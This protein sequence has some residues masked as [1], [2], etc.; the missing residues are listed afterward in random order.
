MILLGSD[1]DLPNPRNPNKSA[2]KEV[3]YSCYTTLSYI[4]CISSRLHVIHKTRNITNALICVC[5]LEIQ[6]TV[7]EQRILIQFV[8]TCGAAEF[9]NLNIVKHIKKG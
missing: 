7:R 8:V 2:L 9:Y 5:P 3:I 6:T 1:S 4:Y